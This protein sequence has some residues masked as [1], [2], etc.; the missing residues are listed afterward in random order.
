[1]TPPSQPA[2]ALSPEAAGPAPPSDEVAAASARLCQ[3]NY[4][5]DLTQAQLFRE[6][7][8]W[9]ERFG[10]PPAPEV[11]A[12]PNPPKPE[13]PLRVGYVSGDFRRH[14]VA[15]FVEPLLRCHDRGAFHPFCYSNGGERDD[16]N[17]HLRA[18]VPDWRD[19]AALDDDAV[20]ALIRRDRI[21]ILVDLS[22]HTAHHRLLVF[23]RR[24]APLQVTAIGYVNTTG[25]AAMDYRLTDAWCDPPGIDETLYSESLWR[26]PGGFNCYAPPNGLPAPGPAPL[27]TRGHV[28]F[29][30]FNNL[31]KISPEVLDL[32]AGLIGSV[33]GSRLVLKTKTLSDPT[34]GAA[35][36]ARFAGAGVDP[37][38]IELIE[39]SATLREHFEHYRRIDIALDPFPYNG[40][41]TTCEALMMGVPVIALAGDRHAARVSAS[42]LARLGLEVLVAPDPAGYLARAQAL[43]QK[44]EAVVKLRDSLRR[45][46]AASPLAD[47]AGY[48]RSLEAAYREMWRRWCEKARLSSPP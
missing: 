25:L 26:L 37:A 31:D 42:I 8:A 45:R 2:A 20:A 39:W 44:P 48:T 15:F 22:G 47:A 3:L 41:T 23:A 21:D 30:S 29:G 12:H 40:T 18:L 9:A 33:P 10:L 38:R 17:M 27:A 19:I 13:R 36:R 32:W 6:H 1:M 11:A 16:L 43:A 5:P 14:P 7:A 28:T 24:P 4:R 34:V 35:I 46:I